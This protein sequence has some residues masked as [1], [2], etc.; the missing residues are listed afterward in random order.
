[1]ICPVCHAE[2]VELKHSRK[3]N[4]GTRLKTI[5][6]IKSTETK[7]NRPDSVFGCNSEIYQVPQNG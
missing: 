3:C 4:C 2:I 7:E 6:R 5:D 1:M